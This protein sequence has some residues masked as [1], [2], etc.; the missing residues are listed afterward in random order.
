MEQHKLKWDHEYNFGLYDKRKKGKIRIEK[1][2]S[3]RGRFSGEPNKWTG[4][5]EQKEWAQLWGS[6]KLLYF[7]SYCCNLLSSW[8]EER[9]SPWRIVSSSCTYKSTIQIEV[10]YLLHF[11]RWKTARVHPSNINIYEEERNVNWLL[12]IREKV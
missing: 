1:S 8:K 12:N 4:C 6:L 2:N 7:S 3:E 9:R 11:S 10:E 5:R